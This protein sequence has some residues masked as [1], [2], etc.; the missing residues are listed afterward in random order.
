MGDFGSRLLRIPIHSSVAD[1]YREWM[2][3]PFV[4][5]CSGFSH[6]WSS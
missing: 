1:A 6:S 4:K 2:V 3:T 5:I